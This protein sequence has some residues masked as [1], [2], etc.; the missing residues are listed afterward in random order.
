MN[1]S[2]KGSSHGG[3]PVVPRMAL[4]RGSP[5]PFSPYLFVF[6]KLSSLIP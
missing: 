5:K 1:R 3:L 6:Q 4:H 2:G